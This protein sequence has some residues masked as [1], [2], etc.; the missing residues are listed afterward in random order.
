MQML[1]VLGILSYE[2]DDLMI[3]IK[4]SNLFHQNV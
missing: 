1:F 2:V 3:S 4:I